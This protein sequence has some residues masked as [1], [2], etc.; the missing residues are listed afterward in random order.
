M[1]I[2]AISDI[3]GNLINI[4]KTDILIIAGDIVPLS[5]QRN[6]ILSELWLK[7]EFT[8][9]VSNI[10]CDKVIFIGGNH[11][12]VLENDVFENS[13]KLIYLKDSSITVD[14][15]KIYG[16]PWCT[17]HNWAFYKN[18]NDIYNAWMNI[19]DDI[20][21]LVTHVPPSVGTYGTTTQKN[22]NYMRDFGSPILTN[23]I[24]TKKPKIHLFGHVHTGNHDM[25]ETLNSGSKLCNVSIL[26]EDYK[27]NYKPYE[28]IYEQ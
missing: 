13:Q 10:D 2:T 17:M 9:W 23:I 8:D 24:E 7:T 5:I 4:S 14:G 18:E 25:S 27:I 26:D 12:F 16:S 1:K 20:D 22:R 21:I 15:I 28:F 11:D 6:L 3:H 19:P